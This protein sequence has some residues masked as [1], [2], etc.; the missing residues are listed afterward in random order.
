MTVAASP[1]RVLVV[2][3]SASHRRLLTA[4]LGQVGHDVL[5]AVN[6]VAALEILAVQP[7]DAVVSDVKMPRMD[8]FQFC[9]ALRRDARWVRLPFVFYSSVFIGDRAQAL[10]MDLGATAYLDAKYVRPEQIAKEIDAVVKRVVSAD[11]QTALVRLHDDLEFARRYHQVVMASLDSTRQA[12][13]RASI[14]SN[15]EALDEILTRLGAERHALAEGI[16]VTVPVAELNQLKELSEYV[17]DAIN[18]PLGIILEDTTVARATTDEA[19]MTAAASV[20]VGVR[21]INELVRK[22]TGRDRPVG[23]R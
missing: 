19:T 23:A 13:V 4:L 5:T 20:R 6:G 22:I 3:D 1:L 2:D 16:D 17:G 15:V 7:V 14:S 11:Y 8:G 10:A 12:G 18:H 9:R 21:R